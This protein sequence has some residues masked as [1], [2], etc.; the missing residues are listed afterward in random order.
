[1]TNFTH[2]RALSSIAILTFCLFIPVDSFATPPATR[3]EPVSDLVQGE[4]IT[5]EY[6]W[7]EMLEKD[8]PEVLAWTTA[9]NDRTQSILNALPC[10]A[11]LEKQLAPLMSIG[12][13]GLPKR[14][15]ASAFWTEREGNQNQPILYFAPDLSALTVSGSA[16][17]ATNG[18]SRTDK[19]VLLDVNT[20]D[21]KGLTSLDWWD[22]SQD[23]R[24]VAFGTSKSGSEM[25]VL[26]VIDVASGQWLSDEISGKVSFDGWSPSGDAFLYS[27]LADPADPYSREIR[28]H[29][30]GHHTRQDPLIYRQKEPS[31]VPGAGLSRDGRW[32]IVSQ[33]HGWQSND[34]F[35]GDFAQ[36]QRAGM[37][38]G[39]FPLVPVAVGLDG[40]FRPSAI[41][42]DTMFMLSSLDTPKGSLWA[43][44]MNSPAREN[45][46]PIIAT[47]PDEVL[48]S[49]AYCGG[50]LVASYSK[51]VCSRIERFTSSG[52]SLGE[53][54][55]P[56]L[57]SA[58][59]ATD[60]T[61]TT[62]FVSYTSFNEPRSIYS[63]DFKSGAMTLWARPTV[64]IDP[65][66]VT[67]SQVFVTSKDGTKIPM[68][69][70]HKAG[71][72]LNGE[73]PTILYGYGG[74]NVSLDPAFNATNWPW[75]EGG[76]VYAIANLR[77]GSEYGED[78]HKAGMR[79]N[80]QNVFDDFYACAEWLIS[81]KFTNSKHL[82]I[83][84]GSNGGLL[85]G[86]AVTQRPDLFCAAISAVP[87][88]DM[89]RYQQFLIAK[90]W[91]PEYG[92]S[93]DAEQFGW[94][95]KYSPYQHVTKG[96]KYP[97]VLFTAGENDSRVHPLHARKM[98][99]RMQ[100]LS[101]N[102]DANDPIL[103]WVDRNAGH[104]QGK[105]L[106][107]RIAEQADQ[108]AFM[109]WQTGMCR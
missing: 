2:D 23:G 104:G 67:V 101:S 4:T 12:S 45:W 74:F 60:E 65:S 102:D 28:W 13:V 71:L 51:D 105:P 73:S 34:L 103:L 29:Q 78:W 99:A 27:Q 81:S 75:Y 64:P 9:Q 44:D 63:V 30:I 8:S 49:V 42:G 79:A 11:Q 37:P 62:G 95:R 18:P 87:L 20:I 107:N 39:S 61:R 91:V 80:K 35:V 21:A 72:V 43:V 56:G 40:N 50:L 93:E 106:A 22:P 10:H 33:S 55:L 1:M 58:T 68:F 25:S 70:V 108:W 14:E 15:G 36:W 7:L 17:A 109:M 77:G 48:E 31:V 46:K 94:I 41:I 32:I 24:R 100:A 59:L 54:K 52:R 3:S 57:G 84:G 85:T 53:I 5:D 88:L 86:V 96:T 19:K 82:A 6:R 90:F 69:I 26:R 16:V 97:A 66:S 76:G 83:Q 98:A 92:S 47:R 38:S 89:I